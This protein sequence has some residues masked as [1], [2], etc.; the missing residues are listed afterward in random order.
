[1]AEGH[2]ALG[3][4]LATSSAAAI[5]L[6]FLLQHR[7]LAK[8]PA[9]GGGALR[10]LRSSLR[11]REWVAGQAL[12]IAG[13][14]A[15]I[16]AVAIAPLALVQAFAAGGLA[17]SLPVAILVFHQRVRP[18]QALAVL[19]IAAALCSLP[20][21]LGPVHERL[22]QT[23][24]AAFVALALTLAAASAHRRRPAGLAIA[25]GL[26]YG[27]GDAA[28]KALA[29]LVGRDGAAWLLGAWLG[30]AA[31]ATFAGFLAFQA[32]LRGG[33]PVTAVTLMTALTA[34]VALACG[35]L[36]LGEPFG[37][38]PATTAG[39]LLAVSVVLICVR[40]LARAQADLAQAAG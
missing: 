35:L 25:A 11:Q 8:L 29:V 18:P 12:G 9:L 1:M 2:L 34:L 37:D 33:P 23:T 7:G 28:I 31:L 3:L 17:V 22:S 13:F 10:L 38:G 39:H 6:G 16:A 32:A 20:L 5:N 15:Q 36:A 21:G 19:A 14:A 26:C 40:P 4:T 24:L 27:A 30:L